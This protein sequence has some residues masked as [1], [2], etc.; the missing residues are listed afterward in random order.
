MSEPSRPRA[1]IKLSIVASGDNEE[2]GVNEVVL[3][4]PDGVT[5]NVPRSW[6]TGV[7]V[8]GAKDAFMDHTSITAPPGELESIWRMATA[9]FNQENS[10]GGFG[11]DPADGDSTVS[12]LDDYN[13]G[14]WNPLSAGE[15]ANLRGALPQVGGWAKGGVGTATEKRFAGG[16]MQFPTI[17]GD[18]KPHSTLL[19]MAKGTQFRQRGVKFTSD[20]ASKQKSGWGEW[21]QV[22]DAKTKRWVKDPNQ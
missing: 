12:N 18:D 10:E 17:Q 4:D 6:V 13:A 21:D 15:V 14:R 20:E 1:G 16:P 5:F 7:D 19:D 11:G 9:K 2:T 3:E 22:W 8:E